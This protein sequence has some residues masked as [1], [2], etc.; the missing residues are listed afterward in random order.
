MQIVRVT[1][2]FNESNLLGTGGFGSVYEGT[3]SDGR[4]VAVKVFNLQLEGAFRSFDSECEVLSQILHRNLV[5]IISCC[6]QV[7]F[8]ALIQYMPNGSLENWMALR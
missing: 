7:D 2:G 1:N 5:K 3:I 6:S 4:N 8:K